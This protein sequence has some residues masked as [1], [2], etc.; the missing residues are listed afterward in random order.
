LLGNDSRIGRKYLSGGLAYGGPCFPRDNKAFAHVAKKFGCEARLSL[1]TDKENEHQN[2]RIAA[3]VEKNIG[4][5]KGKKIS[6]L[7]LSYKA[8]SEVVEESAAVKITS[9][10]LKKCANLF[11]Y[12]PAAMDNARKVLGTKGITYVNS[13]Q[14]CLKDSEFCLLATPWDEF[15]KMSPNDFTGNMKKARL[16]DCWGI[17]N[18]PEFK[19][20]I[21]YY[22][23]G[24]A[25]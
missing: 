18:R 11:V 25:H 12:D 20:K 5:I 17:Y 6:I 8:N 16:L 15:K 24:L 23:I 9:H 1:A 21:D 7:G 22:T 3:L 14:E 10:L 4:S 19:E 13:A 2:E